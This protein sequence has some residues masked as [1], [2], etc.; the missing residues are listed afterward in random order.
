MA[1]SA[2]PYLHPRLS[3]VDVGGKEEPVKVEL[4]HVA[5][6]AAIEMAFATLDRGD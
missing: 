3:S 2:A 4:S 1:R 5:A 6:V